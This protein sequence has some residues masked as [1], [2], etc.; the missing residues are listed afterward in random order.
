MPRESAYLR[1]LTA[2]LFT[3][4]CAW[5]AAA[6][7]APGS[8]ESHVR[9]EYMELYEALE[10]HGI[11]L[12]QE[13]ALCGESLLPASAS[14]SRLAAGSVLGQREGESILSPSSGL[15]FDD[16]DGFEYLSPEILKNLGGAGLE[17]LLARRPQSGEKR[18]GRLVTGR[19][20]YYAAFAPK[21]EVSPEKGRCRLRF[22]GDTE[23]EARLID[24]RDAGERLILIFRLTAEDEELLRLRRCSASL[25]LSD[26]GGLAVPAEA[27]YTDGQGNKFVYC[28]TA[29][30][31]EKTAVECIY[32]SGRL[33][34]VRATEEGRL[35]PGSRVISRA[36]EGLETEG[37]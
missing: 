19:D 13:Q 14:G 30:G 31:T 11:V 28:C 23:R 1:A 35:P 34:L 27:V 10:L 2:L 5:L 26:H 15:Y 6:L 29:L 4:V 32:E 36:A 20:W 21:R 8:A 33:C 18:F 12:R 24:I 7:F 22:E 17:E 9:A 25:I 16:T 37:Y 3:A